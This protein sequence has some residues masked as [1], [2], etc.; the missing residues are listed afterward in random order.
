MIIPP[1]LS[2]LFL[3]CFCFLRPFSSSAVFQCHKLVT[4]YAFE[5]DFVCE[6]A[7]SLKSNPLLIELLNQGNPEV[8]FVYGTML[9]LEW[10]LRFSLSTFRVGLLRH[11]DGVDALTTRSQLFVSQLS[12][13]FLCCLAFLLGQMAIERNVIPNISIICPRLLL[14]TLVLPLLF[15]SLRDFHLTAGD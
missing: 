2:L 1:L 3:M 14:L 15:V 13:R 10:R 12:L 9:C 4:R 7:K 5:H 6:Q 11:R 8:S